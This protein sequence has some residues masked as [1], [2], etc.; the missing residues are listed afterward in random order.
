MT[1]SSTIH[2]NVSGTWKQAN[3]YYVNV[4]G[5]W[6][7]GTEFQANISNVWKGGVAANPVGLPT[8][9]TI[10]SLNLV[11]FSLPT[12]GIIDA[13]ATVNSQTLNLVDFSI[14]SFG[15]DT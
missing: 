11:D 12:I 14:P 5:T 9:A 3:A 8:T 15:M 6:K 13:K 10:L 4:S 1:M 7:T 2:V